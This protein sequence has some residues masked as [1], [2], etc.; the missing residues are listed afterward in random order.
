AYLFDIEPAARYDFGTQGMNF[1]LSGDKY[2]RVPN[3]PEGITVNYWLLA[4][5]STRVQ[6]TVT[7]SAGTVARRLSMSAHRGMNRV[8]IPFVAGG[9]RGRGGGGGGAP[10]FGGGRGRAGTD[11]VGS[12]I[13]PGRYTVTLDVGE[14]RLTKPAL[15]R[16]RIR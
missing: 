7:D 5:D 15:V 14:E 9:G 12:T 13:T 4:G 3:A 11:S 2:L 1:A 10:S 8:V 6:L 16:E